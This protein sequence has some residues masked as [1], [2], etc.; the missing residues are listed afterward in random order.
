M[1]GRTQKLCKLAGHELDPARCFEGGMLEKLL[2][3]ASYVAACGNSFVSPCVTLQQCCKT[4]QSS[5]TC[6]IS[7]HNNVSKLASSFE[8]S[9][10]HVKGQGIA[11]PP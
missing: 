10:L 3:Q 4:R 7:V 5:S 1:R 2:F 9:S 8:L 11:M 6:T